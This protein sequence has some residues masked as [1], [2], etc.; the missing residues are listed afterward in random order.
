MVAPPRL[1]VLPYGGGTQSAVDAGQGDLL[2][3][4]DGAELGAACEAGVCFT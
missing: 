3:E 2:A 4:M 1:R